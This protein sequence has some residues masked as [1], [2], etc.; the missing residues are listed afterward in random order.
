M[1]HV[2]VPFMQFCAILL[3]HRQGTRKQ[4]EYLGAYA[5]GLAEAGQFAQAVD[6]QREI[7][8]INRATQGPAGYASADG[9]MWSLLDLAI[10]LD[11]AG[12]TA[13]S[14]DV[15]REALRVKRRMSGADPWRLAGLVIWLAG[16][17]TRFTDTGHPQEAR[18]LLDEAAQIEP[19]A[20][21]LLV[22][23]AHC[24]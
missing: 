10:Y 23:F 13:A 5:H 17:S 12:Q 9:V 6:L 2:T 1:M 21:G 7:V 4:M 22:D 19:S 8:D 20:R 15:E 14:L 11:L 18:E 24:E 16:V 3:N